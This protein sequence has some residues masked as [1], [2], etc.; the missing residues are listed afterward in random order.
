MFASTV[1]SLQHVSLSFDV[2]EYVAGELLTLGAR[3]IPAGVTQAAL[4][5]LRELAG[6]ALR[7]RLGI[8]NPNQSSRKVC[9]V[10]KCIDVQPKV[11]GL[12]KNIYAR[13][14]EAIVYAVVLMD[15]HLASYAF[16]NR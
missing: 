15:F 2:F 16:L 5:C 12:S 14:C 4:R 8:V 9:S 1:E 10:Y 6:A 3:T 7:G 11:P 13:N